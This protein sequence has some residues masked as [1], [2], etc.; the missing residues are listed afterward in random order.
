VTKVF[1]IER[2]Q[3][4]YVVVDASRL[5]ARMVT[6]NAD[7]PFV[8]QLDR[9]LQAAMVLGMVAERQG[10]LFGLISFSDRIHSFMRARSGRAH[11]NAC[12]D[13]LFT[14]QPRDVDPDYDE[15]ATFIRLRLRRRALLVFLTNLDDPVLAESFTHSM[16][17]IR[18][19]HLILVNMIT[20]PGVAPLFAQPNV[21]STDDVYERLGGHLQ[22]RDLRELQRVLHRRAVRLSLLENESLTPDMVTQYLDV[23]QRQVL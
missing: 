11:Q 12:R 8:P 22:W 4:V 7:A 14:L 2:T 17:L 16:D 1:Q 5:S 6:G 15:L 18:R 13:A 21:Q 23:K 19:N 3:E 10:D 9:F 20:P